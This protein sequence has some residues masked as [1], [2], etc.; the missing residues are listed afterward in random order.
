MQARSPTW[1][2]CAALERSLDFAR[3]DMALLRCAKFMGPP[4]AAQSTKQS[5]AVRESRPARIAPFPAL[6]ARILTW[7]SRTESEAAAVL[8]ANNVSA[9]LPRWG[10]RPGSVSRSDPGRTRL[11][12]TAA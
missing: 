3:H 11:F 12:R 9:I 10:A 8:P 2:T 6:L 5:V 1:V 4:R 7:A